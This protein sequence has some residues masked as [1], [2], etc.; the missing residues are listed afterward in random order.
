V[1]LGD[2]ED[3]ALRGGLRFLKCCFHLRGWQRSGACSGAGLL[4]APPQGFRPVDWA[5]VT[6]VE[7]TIIP[8]ISNVQEILL[9]NIRVVLPKLVGVSCGFGGQ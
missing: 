4:T 8:V 6:V 2:F 7:M 3:A 1:P 9:L 5:R